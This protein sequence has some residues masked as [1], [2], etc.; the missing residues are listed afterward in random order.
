MDSWPCFCGFCC[1][2]LDDPQL[3]I[4]PTEGCNVP[5]CMGIHWAILPRCLWQPLDTYNWCWVAAGSVITAE[6]EKNTDWLLQGKLQW[7]I[8]SPYIV[9]VHIWT[10]WSSELPLPPVLIFCSADA[11]G[12]DPTHI[13]CFG[14]QQ[15]H[16]AQEEERKD[17][18]SSLPLDAPVKFVHICICDIMELPK[19][20]WGRQDRRSAE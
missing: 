4:L 19:A 5:H 12:S 3:G 6:D 15:L 10:V 17:A 16:Q 8:D 9:T 14:W 11:A 13:L 2:L 20:Q 7:C 1:R 18:P